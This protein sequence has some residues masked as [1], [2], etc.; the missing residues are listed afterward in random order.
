MIELLKYENQFVNAIRLGKLKRNFSQYFWTFI[1]KTIKQRIK[2][3][4]HSSLE[5][6]LPSAVFL[7][8]EL[9]VK[10]IIF[11]SPSAWPLSTGLVK[12][13]KLIICNRR[14]S[15]HCK[16]SPSRLINDIK[17]QIY[18]T[19]LTDNMKQVQTW[20]NGALAE[21]WAIINAQTVGLSHIDQHLG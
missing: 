12:F 1:A 18:T 4:Y 3:N 8:K 14:G 9:P 19:T 13:I 15:F 7:H 17:L 20:V 10:I 2:I 5:I 6:I 21:P 16:C 11:T